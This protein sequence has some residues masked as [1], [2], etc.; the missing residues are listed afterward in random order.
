MKRNFLSV[1]SSNCELAS[2]MYR[3]GG[4]D[5]APSN[6]TPEPANDNTPEPAND[7]TPDDSLQVVNG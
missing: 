5:C 2:F 6:D 4:Y 3:G 1:Q 7:N